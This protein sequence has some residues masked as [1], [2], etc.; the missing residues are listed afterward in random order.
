MRLCPTFFTNQETVPSI[1]DKLFDG[2]S[3][4]WCKPPYKLGNF[5]TGEHTILHEMTHLS[6]IGVAVG[7]ADPNDP[8]CSSLEGTKDILG[9][10]DEND[11]NMV[12]Y[13]GGE[14][15][16]APIAATVLQKHWT[17]HLG[18][19]GGRDGEEC[20]AH[21]TS[22]AT[23]SRAVVREGEGRVCLTWLS[24][25]DPRCRK[26]EPPHPGAS[27]LPA[28]LS[29]ALVASHLIPPRLPRR[30]RTVPY[31]SKVPPAPPRVATAIY[32]TMPEA[33]PNMLVSYW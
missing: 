10:P 8:D 24:L 1:Q 19:E 22:A 23:T 28:L 16:Y 18:Q 5:M 12:A 17:A 30:R 21:A 20:S 3:N 13:R 9:E 14:K 4:G 7:L 2:S 31:H 27:I 25:P 6:M 15:G 29:G 26:P 11:K 32:T 33:Q